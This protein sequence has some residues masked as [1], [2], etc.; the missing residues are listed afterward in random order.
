MDGHSDV[1]IDL[2]ISWAISKAEWAGAFTIIR[3]RRRR[4]P[5]ELVPLS[6]E[7]Q[8]KL[9][10]FPIKHSYVPHKRYKRG[11][12]RKKRPQRVGRKNKREKRCGLGVG[13]D[14]TLLDITILY[15]LLCRIAKANKD[16]WDAG[17]RK[18][19]SE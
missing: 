12:A 8:F 19:P 14:V 17:V 13:L 9:H 2:W 7:Y 18:Q 15:T 11:S 3:I 10:S 1:I 6:S 5:R 16:C 4:V